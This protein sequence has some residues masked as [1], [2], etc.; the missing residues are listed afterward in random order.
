MARPRELLSLAD[1][2]DETGISYATLRNYTLKYPDEIPSEGDGR[3]TRYPRAAVKVFQRLRKESK[4]GRKPKSASVLLRPLP[5]PAPIEAPAPVRP[6]APQPAPAP[7][8]TATDT[9]GMERELAAIRVFLGRIA[10]SLEQLASEPR[11][12]A[13]APAPAAAAPEET[14][15]PEAP[16]PTAPTASTA[17]TPAAP[18]KVGVPLPPLTRESNDTQEPG[19]Y[20]RLHSLPKVR[21]QRGRRPE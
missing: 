20:R 7:R 2:A 9:S 17:P 3:N 21:G 19:S 8:Q 14:K 15:R 1:I 18:Q 5:A 10:D 16:A 11:S 12:A 4:P 6:P 13:P